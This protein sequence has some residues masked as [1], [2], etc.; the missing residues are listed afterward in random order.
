M[1]YFYGIMGWL[2]LII[3]IIVAIGGSKEVF[4]IF[5][6]S[7]LCFVMAELGEIKELIK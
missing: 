2:I 4:G 3:G 7:L 1:K 5:T 6:F